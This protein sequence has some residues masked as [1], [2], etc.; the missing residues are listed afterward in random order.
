M[1]FDLKRISFCLPRPT[2][3]GRPVPHTAWRFKVSLNR[4]QSIN[5]LMGSGFSRGGLLGS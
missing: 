1:G 4:A 3:D 2:Q 5:T